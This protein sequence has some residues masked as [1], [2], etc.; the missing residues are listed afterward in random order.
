MSEEPRQK[1]VDELLS[2][3]IL[4]PKGFALFCDLDGTLAPIVESPDQVKVSAQTRGAIDS[5]SR[6]LGICAIVTGRP[7]RQ[8]RDLIGVESIT[9]AGNH[10]LETLE[11]GGEEIRSHPLLADRED[12]ASGFVESLDLDKLGTLGIRIEDK[13]PI[14]ALH[15]RGA[16]ES[17]ELTQEIE[18][19]ASRAREAR[20]DPRGGRKVLE[21]RP[22]IALD[23][24]V[25]VTE[26]LES[27]PEVDS[28]IFIGDD[29]TDLDAF[30]A[31]DRLAAEGRI[32]SLFK[33]AVVSDETSDLDLSRSADICLSGPD[34]VTKL[35][36]GLGV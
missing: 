1:Q 16:H 10:G 23:K 29:A 13:G 30:D 8:A 5:A 7:A 9:I 18:Q 12:E 14:V 31:L 27:R 35:I 4:R 34:E 2:Q 11:S 32:S 3:V 15:W 22:R 21:L 28:A 6:I 17:E 19:I 25:A 20:L 33:I 24:G 26:L 36:A